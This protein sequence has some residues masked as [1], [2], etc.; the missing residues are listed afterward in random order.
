MMFFSR[1]T[2]LLRTLPNHYT[3]NSSY[4]W[5]ALMTPTSMNKFLGNLGKA[6]LYDFKRPEM[7]KAVQAVND[8]QAVSTIIG[9]DSGNFVAPYGAE[10][11]ALIN[12]PW[13]VSSLQAPPLFISTVP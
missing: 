13:F 11:E 10:A 1:C 6:D 8:F 4:T 9:K 5:F 3:D 7:G 12:G 2:V